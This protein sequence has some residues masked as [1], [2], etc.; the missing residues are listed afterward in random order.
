MYCTYMLSSLRFLTQVCANMGH[1][2]MNKY[3]RHYTY[4]TKASRGSY[5]TYVVINQ[6]VSIWF[7]SRKET[8]VHVSALCMHSAYSHWLTIYLSLYNELMLRFLTLRGASVY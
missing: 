8:T 7:T 4:V 3:I 2:Q 5:D 1:S 6:L